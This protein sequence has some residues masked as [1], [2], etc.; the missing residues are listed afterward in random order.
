MLKPCEMGQL[1]EWAGDGYMPPTGDFDGVDGIFVPSFG[2]VWDMNGN[3]TE[4]GAT[5]VALADYL[6]THEA[7]RDAIVPLYLQQEVYMAALECD[8]SVRRQVA[9]VFMTNKTPGHAYNTREVTQQALPKLVDQ[10]V[11]KLALLP[12]R[13]HAPRAL[14]TVNKVV[15]AE[16]IAVVYPGMQGI[17][18]FDPK[19]SQPRT[20][21]RNAWV[22]GERL[23][24]PM[25][26][27]L[28]YI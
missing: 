4:P 3:V 11:G 12:F 14:P 2:T 22:K 26:A 20:R 13:H 9:Q 17:G 19:S 24:I 15:E 8:P 5:N 27:I 23:I 1:I 10:R 25:S 21:N 6:V 16:N 7:I 28:G 18:D